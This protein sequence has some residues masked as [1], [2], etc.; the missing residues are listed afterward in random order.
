VALNRDEFC[1]LS[2]AVAAASGLALGKHCE[3]TS[4]TACATVQ[5]ER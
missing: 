1:V 2:L 5:K 3:E 4:N